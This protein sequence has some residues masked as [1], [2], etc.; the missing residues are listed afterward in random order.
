MQ[1]LYAYYWI[2]GFIV[3]SNIHKWKKGFECLCCQVCSWLISSVSDFH[4]CCL[5]LSDEREVMKIDG[6]FCK[7]HQFNGNEVGHWDEKCWLVSV[8]EPNISLPET[9]VRYW[10]CTVLSDNVQSYRKYHTSLSV[11]PASL[12]KQKVVTLK[13]HRAMHEE[14]IKNWCRRDTKE[15]ELLTQP[16]H[17]F[18]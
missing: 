9:S 13:I 5:N 8:S 15:R 3:S 16:L 4:S 14:A 10:N 12:Y 7:L 18:A 6:S 2:P 17:L 11:E 1:K